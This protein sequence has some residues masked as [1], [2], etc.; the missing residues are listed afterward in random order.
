[1][2][3][4]LSPTVSPKAVESAILTKVPKATV[5]LDRHAL[6]AGMRV[7]KQAK[8]AWMKSEVLP[9]NR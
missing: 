1:M 2:N 3:A 9:K 4:H 8:K 5:K 6:K 7:A